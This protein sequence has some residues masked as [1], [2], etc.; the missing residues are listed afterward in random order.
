MNMLAYIL[1]FVTA[2]Q[3]AVSQLPQIVD[4]V[5]GVIAKGEA[6]INTAAPVASTA[7]IIAA[8]GKAAKGTKLDPHV[9]AAVVANKVGATAAAELAAQPASAGG[10]NGSA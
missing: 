3:N 4:L 7:A 9:V 5:D 8:V 1:A 2:F 10:A 6:V